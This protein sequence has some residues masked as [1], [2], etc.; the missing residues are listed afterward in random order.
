M[1]TDAIRDSVVSKDGTRIGF[2]KVGSG[3]PIVIV[4]GSLTTGSSWLPVANGLKDLFTCYLMDRRGRGASGDASAYSLATEADDIRAVLDRAGTDAC[5]MGHSYGA[6]CTLEA[7]VANGPHKLIIYE[8]PLPI[9]K[10][11]V[12]AAFRDLR[13]AVQRGDSD[14]GLTIGL[15]DMVRV[16]PDELH[17]LRQSPLWS[18]MVR[19]TPGWVREIQEISNLDFGVARYTDIEAPTLLLLG[20]ATAPHHVESTRALAAA[21]PDA[22]TVEFEGHSHF[23]HLTA[24]DQFVAALAGFM[25]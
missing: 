11:V 20:T 24:T 25:R 12:G 3:P 14:E 18:E 13:A 8:A 4:H 6:I 21:L 1:T 5:L 2:E 23:A 7:A 19:L 15:R 22:R 16:S 10:K 17:G 9:S